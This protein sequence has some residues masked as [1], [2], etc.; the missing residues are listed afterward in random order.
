MSEL[1]QGKNALVTRL[2][3]RHLNGLIRM[4]VISMKAYLYSDI[5]TWWLCDVYCGDGEQVIDGITIDGSPIELFNAAEA[6]SQLPNF[7]AHVGR[8]RFLVSDKRPEAVKSVVRIAEDKFQHGPDL[9]GHNSFASLLTAN[10][11]DAENTLDDIHRLLIERPNDRA[12]VFLDPNG[13]ATFAYPSFVDLLTDDRVRDRVDVVVNISATALKRI[14]GSVKASA[15]VDW[16]GRMQTIFV[17]ALG[18]DND[19]T[20]CW[21]RE[22]VN[23]DPWQ[24][25]MLAYWSTPKPQFTWDTARFVPINS[26]KG[27]AALEFYSRTAEEARDVVAN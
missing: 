15:H 27:R 3:E 24:W 11:Q 26:P 20:G 5:A 13:P 17:S 19:G 10:V 23:R 4:R 1:F 25:C 21:I 9:L 8:F 7:R 14:R 12:F 18:R 2:K 16:I 6:L 22:P